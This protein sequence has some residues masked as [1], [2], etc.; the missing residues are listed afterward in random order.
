M[1]ETEKR[2]LEAPLSRRDFVRLG[3][4]G[5]AGTALGPAACAPRDADEGSTAPWW[6]GAEFELEEATLADLSGSMAS[7]ALTS[8]DITRLYLERIANL[9]RAGPRLR[10]LIEID[11]VAEETAERLDEE[12]R[13]GRL[14]GPLHGIPVVVKDNI[15]TADRLTTTA[16]SLALA[17]HVAARDSHVVARLREAGAIILAKAN[18]SEWANFRSTRSNSGWSARGGQCANAYAVDRNPCGSSSGSAAAVSAN[19]CAAS[20]GTETNGSVVCPSSVNGLVGLKPTVGLVSRAGIIPIAHSQDTAGPITRTVRDAATLLSVFA[21]PD[22]RDPG[23]AEAERFAG[24]DYTSFL[25]AEGLRGARIGVERSYFGNE[26]AVDHLMEEAIRAMSAAG[27]TIVDDAILATRQ[28]IGP[29]SY[30]VLLHEFK[31]GLGAYLEA[32]GR[33]NGMAT[34]ADVIAFNE[35]NAEREMPW[36]GQEIFE[37][38]VQLGGLDAP[39]YLEALETMRRLSR[40]EGID[41]LMEQHELDAIVAPTTRAAWKTDLVNGDMSSAGA[42]SPAA[43]AGY[44]S[45]TVP[46]GYIH[47]LPVGILFFGRAW[48]EGTLLRIAYAYEQATGHRSPAR[49]L[50]TLDLPNV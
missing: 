14:R 12:R 22:P 37:Q 29:P 13:A 50:P 49:L 25:D 32:A 31:A 45:I 40:A 34:L 33:P 36:F 44:P 19:F 26:P 16:G 43:I 23:S 46:N 9:D 18:L 30:Q 7:G 47:G 8:G 24:T 39:E 48:S 28:R 35:A 2:G 41:A 20:L 27:A 21:G 11:P 17:G 42:S 15:D 4:L 6:V 5:A 38:A 1:R 3:A 10:S